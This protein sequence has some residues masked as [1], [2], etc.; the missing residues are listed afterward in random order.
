MGSVNAIE[1]RVNG[2][3][4]M[5]ASFEESNATFG[6][7]E[8]FGW[9]IALDVDKM[10]KGNNT[11]EIRGLTE[12]GQ[13]LPIIMTVTGQGNSASASESLFH[14]LHLDFIFIVSF[15]VV[16]LLLWY[17]RTSN[18]ETLTLDSNESI[19]KVLKD[20]VDIASVVDAELLD[21]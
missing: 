2:G 17:G 15:I 21:G 18:P 3:N 20:D 19:D 12:D 7:L 5:S 14:K 8:G 9:S 13:S 16:A 1:Y 11:L 10:P 4:W 6:A